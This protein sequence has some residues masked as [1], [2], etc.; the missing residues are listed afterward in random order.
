MKPED[1]IKIGMLT[2][3]I[4]MV[5]A[6]VNTFMVLFT[7][8]HYISESIVRHDLIRSIVF[9]NG[10]FV[11]YC[12]CFAFTIRHRL[13][14]TNLLLLVIHT[15]LVVRAFFRWEYVDMSD[16]FHPF[17]ELFFIFCLSQGVIG[18][19]RE[20]LVRVTKVETGEAN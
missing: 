6:L 12:V 20:K 8:R 1:Q 5:L 2:A 10:L 18:M 4:L 13:L 3:I 19:W 7:F 9:P 17:F 14:K 11:L 16:F 15:L